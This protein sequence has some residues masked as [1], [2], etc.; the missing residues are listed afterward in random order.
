MMKILQKKYEE[1]EK[2]NLAQ[3]IEKI[4][5]TSKEKEEDDV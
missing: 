3:E 2:H 5:E 1:E 4:K